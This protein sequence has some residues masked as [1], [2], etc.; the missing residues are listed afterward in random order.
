MTFIYPAV[1]T[2]HKDGKGYH[3]RFPDLDGCEAEGPDLEDALD[4]AR[5]A[6]YNWVLA[7]LEEEQP[8]FPQV[9]HEEDIPLSKDAFVRQIMVSVKLLPDND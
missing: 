4:E 2:P 5:A 3:V 8:D 7:E 9:S 6:A 1:F